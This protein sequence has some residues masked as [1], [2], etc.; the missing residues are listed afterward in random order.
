M[1]ARRLSFY[2]CACHITDDKLR[3]SLHLAGITVLHTN[4]GAP[5]EPVLVASRRLWV[6]VQ[7]FCV[8]ATGCSDAVCPSGT[9]EVMSRCIRQ[10]ARTDD[11][12]TSSSANTADPNTGAPTPDG[13]SAGGVSGTS[14][15]S[16]VR[17]SSQAGGQSGSAT[18][19]M[20]SG[21]G[22]PGDMQA[23]GREACVGASGARVCVGSVLHIC[24]NDGRTAA[25]MP[26]ENETLCQLG[27]STGKCATCSPGTHRCNGAELSECRQGEWAVIR[28]CDSPGLCNADAGACTAMACQPNMK[29]CG[30]NGDLKTCNADGSEFS[31]TQPCGANLCD[32]ENQ[33]C[34]KCVPGAT[35]CVG[36]AA[37]ATC[38]PDGQGSTTMDCASNDECLTAACAGDACQ[39]TPKASGT[40]CSAGKCDGVGRCMGCLAASDCKPQAECYMA[41]CTSGACMN[42]PKARGVSCSNGRMC[43]GRGGCVQC[44]SEA[45]CDAPDCTR[46]TCTAGMCGTM[47]SPETATCST[48]VCN[49]AG[50]CVECNTRN[51]SKCS[52]NEMCMSNQC[53]AKPCGN[54]VIDPGELCETAG[55]AA[56]EPGSC[57]ATQCRLT[58]TAYYPCRGMSLCPFNNSDQQGWFCAPNGAC[59]HACSVDSQCRTVSGNAQCVSVAGGRFCGISC[60]RVGSSAGCPAG[61]TCIDT[62]ALGFPALCGS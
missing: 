24:G 59:S 62:S 18:V 20:S 54:G 34:N 8:L 53:I 7:T 43:D 35:R 10:D 16:A 47:P 42:T 46:A 21:R 39:T 55:P 2:G 60:S 44:V 4:R 33:R 31:E 25:E 9:V 58:D 17:M 22:T 3:C 15:G 61:L 56:Y 28:S 37:L 40:A 19:G 51:S 36:S 50:K 6:W 27:K 49:G 5:L 41:T 14:G 52:S 48:G 13:G 57:D 32:A 38:A 1:C 11:Q 30:L 26:C 45:D 29:G 23:G 12:S